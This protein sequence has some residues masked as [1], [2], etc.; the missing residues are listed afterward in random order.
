MNTLS[1]HH[2]ATPHSANNSKG[3]VSTPAAAVQQT[4]SGATTRTA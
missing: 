3:V 4:F 1:A 2:P